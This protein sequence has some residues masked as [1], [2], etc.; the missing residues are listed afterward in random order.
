MTITKTFI[1]SEGELS[2]EDLVQALAGQGFDN[3]LHRRPFYEIARSAYL[4]VG[5]PDSEAKNGE[6]EEAVRQWCAFELMRGYGF[7]VNDLS[8]ESQVR[9]GSKSYWI[10]ILVLRNGTPWIVVECKAPD[11]KNDKAIEQAISYADSPRIQAEYVLYTNGSDWQVCRRLKGQWMP[12]LDLPCVRFES[13]DSI[14]ITHFF[15]CFS[16]VAPLLYKLDETVQGKEAECFLHALQRFFC[17]WNLLQD[18]VDKDLAHCADNLLRVMSQPEAHYDYRCGKYNNAR[19]EFGRFQARHKIAWEVHPIAGEV[20]IQTGFIE[21]SSAVLRA[22][23]G[24]SKSAGANVLV[25]RFIA[26]LLDYGIKAE[27]SKTPFPV[28]TAN[29][30]H[31][32]R[33]FLQ[34]QFKTKF[35]ATL[36]DPVDQISSSDFKLYCSRGWEDALKAV[37]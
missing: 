19:A 32:L 17:G 25:L 29:I 8:F 27:R 3:Q 12:V 15:A 1:K 34:Y 33:E 31:S 14:D 21:L 16:D 18:G 35:D 28:I 6:P 26:A 24:T 36:P 9:V 7:S 11:A 2:K 13:S 4:H 23:E 20:P 5:S 22:M 30:H 10:D 37:E